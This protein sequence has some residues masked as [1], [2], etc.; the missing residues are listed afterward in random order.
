MKSAAALQVVIVLLLVA[1]AASCEVA[2][3]YSTRVFKP[4]IPQ[5]NTDSAMALKFM[6]FDSGNPTDSIDLKEFFA[7]DVKDGDK[8]KVIEEN[9]EVIRDTTKTETVIIGNKNIP[10]EQPIDATKRGTTRSKRV[11]Q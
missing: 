8:P 11:R 2:K 5:K 3:E 4:A 9:S 1:S 10:K 6:Q 7:K